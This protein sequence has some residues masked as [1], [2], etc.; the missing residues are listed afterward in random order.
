MEVSWTIDL[1]GR[2]W[3]RTGRAL[4]S[5][6]LAPMTIGYASTDGEFGWRTLLISHPE[7]VDLDVSQVTDLG[8]ANPRVVR[9]CPHCVVEIGLLPALELLD[10][11]REGRCNEPAHQPN[12]Y[13][14]IV[15]S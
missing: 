7:L 4:W 12:G 5:I 6:K 10:R 1:S 14:P 2:A 15:S 9:D 13:S 3:R 8:L 11:P